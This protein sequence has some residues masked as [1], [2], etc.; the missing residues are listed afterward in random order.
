MSAF[1]HAL[2][3]DVEQELGLVGR[4]VG[5]SLCIPLPEIISLDDLY[6]KYGPRIQALTLAHPSLDDVF[7]DLTGEHLAAAE[8]EE[9]P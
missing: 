5:R 7:V 4:V 8:G 9:I 3:R 1:D 6:R 2:R